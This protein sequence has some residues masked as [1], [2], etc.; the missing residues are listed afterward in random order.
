MKKTNNYNTT[1]KVV[2]VN[3]HFG[4]SKY[5]ML[6][7]D[8]FVS[9]DTHKTKLNNNDL[10]IGKSG[11]GKSTCYVGPLIEQMCGS[12]VISDTKNTLY[13]KHADKLKA[14]GYNVLKLDMIT[15]E[16]SCSYNPLEFVRYDETT[17][18]YNERDVVVLSEMLCNDKESKDPF[19]G[20]SARL[21]L[22]SLI[23]YMYESLPFEE[24]HMG[25]LN[26]MFCLCE[27][28]RKLNQLMKELEAENPDS[29]AVSR[30]KRF[31]AVSSAEKTY[32]CILMYV[33]NS[34]SNYDCRETRDVFNKRNDVDFES[35]GKKKTA[36]FVNISD[37]ER[38]MDKVVGVLYRD[39]LGKLMRY[40]DSLPEKR[41][42]VHVKF[43]LD[44][45]A[46]GSKINDFSKIISVIRSREISVSIIC[47][48]L[49]QLSELYTPDEAKTIISNCDHL[50]FYGC[51]DVDTAEYISRKINVPAHKIS[52]MPYDV[53]YVF[54]AGNPKGGMRVNKY[55]PPYITQIED[56]DL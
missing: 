33:A 11:S 27:D 54:E 2:N 18:R 47:Q 46:S 14:A 15:G 22:S 55:F 3:N 13:Y 17:D 39:I 8:L 20:E 7:K 35:L 26:K 16:D 50:L 21:F 23:A 52:G 1:K 29:F 32:A 51:N 9:N 25:S 37:S 31:K 40:A 56:E 19:W 43:I 41:L 6:A 24:I 36:L 45:F 48:T 30:Y 53:A 34:I 4:D 12:M 5:R 42:P 28:Q 49:F 10:I 38:S 44:D